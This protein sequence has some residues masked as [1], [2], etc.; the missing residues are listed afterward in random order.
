MLL[1]N[2]RTNF[3]VKFACYLASFVGHR[4]VVYSNRHIALKGQEA[5]N[6]KIKI[7]TLSYRKLFEIKPEKMPSGNNLSLE[8]TEKQIGIPFK[9]VL[10]TDERKVGVAFR[11]NTWSWFWSPLTRKVANNPVMANNLGMAAFWFWQKEIERYNPKIIFSGSNSGLFNGALFFA[12]SSK[13]VKI[14][15][16]RRSKI[17]GGRYY[18]TNDWY[19]QNDKSLATAAKKIDK[20]QAQPIPLN[21]FM[22]ILKNPTPVQ[23]IRENWINA[24]NPSTIRRLRKYA[25]ALK[26]S[27]LHRIGAMKGDRPVG[28]LAHLTADI[29]HFINKITAKR[30]FRILKNED[31]LQMRYVY[32]SMH[33]EPE[34]AL[35]QYC[36]LYSQSGSAHQVGCRKLA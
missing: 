20:K 33:K 28:A 2:Q 12:A 10:L 14:M 21:N 25:G 27:T 36:S 15:I 17:L 6:K 18:W 30:Y 23:Y 4:V 13:H 34:V 22:Q 31:L 26:A 5:K 24:A 11:N 1:H 16:N 32:F 29:I 19:E 35:N 8:N 9:R 3:F 7:R